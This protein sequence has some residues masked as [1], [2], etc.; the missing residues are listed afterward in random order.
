VANAKSESTSVSGGRLEPSSFVYINIGVRAIDPLFSATSWV[1]RVRFFL[2]TFVFN[3]IVGLAYN[4][5]LTLKVREASLSKPGGSV[6]DGIVVWVVDAILSPKGAIYQSQA[7]KDHWLATR[8]DI[9]SR[10]SALRGFRQANARRGEG[11]IPA[12]TFQQE[13]RLDLP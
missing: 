3:D 2:S 5:F 4:F 1:E 11:E 10:G 12:F 7:R 9:P 8:A 6:L 13:S